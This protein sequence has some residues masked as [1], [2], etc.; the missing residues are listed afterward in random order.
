VE[1]ILSRLKPHRL[2]FGLLLATFL[3]HLINITK[4]PIF[5]DES[6]YL[7]WAWTSWHIPGHAFDSLL[8]AKQPLMIWIFG[9]SEMIFADP[10][11]AGRLVSVLFGLLTAIG[12]YLVTLRL[13]RNSVAHFALATLAALLYLI[14]RS[15]CSIF[16][17]P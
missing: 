15:S 5:N 16:A 7:D 3:I 10:L 12:I 1:K 6:I 8:D 13:F 17:K 11:F 2:F 14:T 4:L 9:L